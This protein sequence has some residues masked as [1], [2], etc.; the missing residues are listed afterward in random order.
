ME[1]RKK[2]KSGKAEA[3]AQVAEN[4]LS[5]SLLCAT[6]HT[7]S[8][9]FTLPTRT[10]THTHTTTHTQHTHTRSHTHTHTHTRAHTH[11]HTHTHAHT[12]THTR[13]VLEQN[14]QT[15][16]GGRADGWAHKEKS[17]HS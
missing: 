2:G 9:R 13:T 6:Q 16:G 17:A 7:N 10:L 5:A 1:G 15:Q 8:H 12:H 14:Q 3:K 4:P 11:T